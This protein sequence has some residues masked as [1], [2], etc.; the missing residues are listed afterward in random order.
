MIFIIGCWEDHVNPTIQECY[1]SILKIIPAIPGPK[2]ICLS[3]NHNSIDEDW[4]CFK[5]SQRVFD[6]EQGVQWIKHI[7]QNKQF[8][9]LQSA[10]G[11]C[12][13][14]ASKELYECNYQ[15]STSYVIWHQAQ[16]EYLLNHVYPEVE[17]L[18]YFGI[19]WNLGVMRD[20]IGWGQMC[21]LLRFNHVR[22]R[23]LFTVKSCVLSNTTSSNHGFKYDKFAHPELSEYNW[24]EVQPNL[25]HKKDFSWQYRP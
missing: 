20:P 24:R 13:A 23:N 10:P 9:L 2:I 25:F 8:K 5:N 12:F 6:T 17:N 22:Q 1:R 18:W 15:D 11:D 7:W 3:G 14:T 4:L 16:V 21:D 19:G